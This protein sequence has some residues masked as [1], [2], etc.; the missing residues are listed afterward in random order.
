MWVGQAA[1][2]YPLDRT[3]SKMFIIETNVRSQA[4]LRK[5]SF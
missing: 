2:I 4:P 1:T 3:V 5:Y